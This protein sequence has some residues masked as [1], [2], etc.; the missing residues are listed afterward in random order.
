ME[1]FWEHAWRISWKCHSHSV[2]TIDFGVVFKANQLL[3]YQISFSELKQNGFTNPFSY[4]TA[5]DR[6]EAM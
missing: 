2:Q 6:R 1:R 4:S 3:S 5:R